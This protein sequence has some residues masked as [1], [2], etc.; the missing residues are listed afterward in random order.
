MPVSLGERSA[1]AQSLFPEGVEHT[2]NQIRMLAHMVRTVGSRHLIVRILGVPQAETVVVLGGED[3]VLEAAVLGCLRPFLRLEADGIEGFVQ[4]VILLLELLPIVGPVHLV[5][6]PVGILVAQSPGCH[7]PQLTVNSPV[8][9][10][11]KL[12][13]PKPL[14]L[15]QHGGIGGLYICINSAVVVDALLYHFFLD[16]HFCAHTNTSFL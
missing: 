12:L 2:L 11:G 15:L 3:E 1:D 16:F 5:A 7:Y 10:Q 4:S 14:E 9:H 13:I 6:G 8:Y